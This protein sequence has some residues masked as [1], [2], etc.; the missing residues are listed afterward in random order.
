MLKEI[1]LATGLL[2]SVFDLLKKDK[3]QDVAGS[4]EFASM[5]AGGMQ[6]GLGGFDS[7]LGKA[8]DG[9]NINEKDPISAGTRDALALLR[10]MTEGGLEGAMKYALKKLREDVMESMGVSEEAL[11][12]MPEGERTAMEQK[13]AEEVQRR[14]TDAMG[15]DKNE[16]TG[17]A[18]SPEDLL[19]GLRKA[20]QAEANRAYRE[21][22]PT[23]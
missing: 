1:G 12:A 15:K 11:A 2:G 19:A 6:V 17:G 10:E 18:F 7:P 14:L 21:V 13:I 23:V 8:D 20:V 22:T 4:D 9:L 3:T 5:M 16:M